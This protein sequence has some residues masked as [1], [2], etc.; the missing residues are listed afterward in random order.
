MSVTRL[1]VIG[2]DGLEPSLVKRWTR[3][4]D[5][6]NLA[7]L[8]ETARWG[9]LRT[10]VPAATFPAWTTFLTGVNP[11]QHGIFDFARFRPGTRD[12][13]FVGASIRRRP[14]LP[15][16][17]S[18]AGLA[19]ACLGF[20][21]TYPPE[22]IDGVMIS[23]FD[24]PVAVG[25]DP[26]FVYPPTLARELGRK[27]GRYVFADFAETNTWVPGWHRRAAKKL[28]DGLERRAA[29]A[30]HLATQRRWDLFM[31]HFGESDT[32]AHHFWAFHDPESPRRPVAVDSKLEG[33]LLDVY[34]RL[35]RAVGRL[36]ETTGEETTVLIG[37]DH[38]FG[39]S[40]DKVLYLNRWLASEGWLTFE[41]GRR[42]RDRVRGSAIGAALKLIPGRLQ[43][44][45]WRLAPNLA[46]KLE[47]KRRMAGISWE[48][49][50]VFSEEL[51]Y[52]PSLRLNVRGRWPGGIVDPSDVSTLTGALV[53]AL[54]ELRDPWTG[55][56]VV[57]K[58]WR[59]HE[60]YS[61]PAVEDAPDLLLE[62]E[63]DKNYSINVL[64]SHDSG[65]VW[66]RLRAGERLGAKGAGMN[67]THR[68]NGFW[69]ARGPRVTPRRKQAEIAD[70]APTALSA[71]GLTPPEWMEGVSQVRASGLAVAWEP[72]T[73]TP[74][75]EGAPAY[76][77]R[78]QRI[79]E[80][81]LRRLGYL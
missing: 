8:R 26:S 35:D 66:R 80:E 62:F 78:Q 59:R 6:P 57:K 1:L 16:L 71:L 75:I 50:A 53:S 48:E 39:G 54:A 43:E 69:L 49:T 9:P 33:V 20:P 76:T 28:V 41:T 10:T 12:V 65:P 19:V 21:G 18:D 45:A 15:R 30:V 63:L 67:G 51:S 31:V 24:S 17:A 29:I 42:E 27:F 5:L 14:I 38:G 37:S 68:R 52:H 55:A 47:G 3:S 7:R 13:E 70:M 56:K 4:G 25:I 79:L 81:R 44:R 58:A 74:R 23:G 2:L 46:G 72:E 61:G 34:R 36:L 11:G 22:P 77:Q 32:A 64:P 60:L 73:T 40:S